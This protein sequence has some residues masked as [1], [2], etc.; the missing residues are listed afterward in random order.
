MRQTIDS[1]FTVFDT[2][3]NLNP[4]QR[5]Q[6]EQR[7]NAIRKVLDEA[8]F[9]KTIFLQGSF[10]RKTMLA[11][12]KDVDIV[13]VIKAA[14]WQELQGPN[15]PATA[16]AWFKN[17]VQSHWPNAEF[18]QGDTPSGKAL[19]VTFSDLDFDIDLVP[20]FD[21]D[22]GPEVVI[23]DRE[24][25]RWEASNTR[26]QIAAVSTRNQGTGGRFVHQVRELKALVKNHEDQLG[27]IKGI[28]VESL[29]YA[30]ITKEKADKHAIAAALSHAQTA[31][32]GPILEPAGDDDV[33][34]KWTASDRTTAGLMFADFAARADEAIELEAHGDIEAAKDVWHSLFGDAFPPASARAPET[35]LATWNSPGTRTST[36]RPSLSQGGREA[37]TPGRAWA[38][39]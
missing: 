20:A 38:P 3:L 2:S 11:P 32:R 39:R 37:S 9:V 14:H 15:G 36:G 24:Q 7:H 28:V 1:A 5:E 10:A 22:E 31:V 13:I 21:L 26:R 30:A 6:A 17:A 8:G 25:R 23:G 19:R 27:F 35:V 4:K 34:V 29:A 33:T 16:M 12:L 18:D